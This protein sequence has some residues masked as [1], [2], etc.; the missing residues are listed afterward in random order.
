MYN[1]YD[2]AQLLPEEGVGSCDDKR[3]CFASFSKY[4]ASAQFAPKSARGLNLGKSCC[5]ASYCNVMPSEFSLYDDD[6][7]FLHATVRMNTACEI[8]LLECC[9]QV[10]IWKV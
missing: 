7:M 6:E 9:S 2:C 1:R 4:L 5:L 10:G 3:R 8:G